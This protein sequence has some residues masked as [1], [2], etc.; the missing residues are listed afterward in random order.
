MHYSLNNMFIMRVRVVH[1]GFSGVKRHRYRDRCNREIHGDR[2]RDI[3]TETDIETKRQRQR[4]RYRYE[5]DKNKE[6]KETGRD[7]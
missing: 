1:I 6:E 4:D 2:G 7:T 5:R 3:K